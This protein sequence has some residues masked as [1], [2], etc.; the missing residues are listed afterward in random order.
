MTDRT[1]EVRLALGSNQGDR[2]SM[3]SEAR[4]RLVENGLV[5]DVRASMVMETEAVG[6]PQGPF[7]NQVIAGVTTLEPAE[8]LKGVKAIE[9]DMGRVPSPRWGPRLID[10]DI[11]TLGEFQFSSSDLTIPHREI[12]ARE[13]VLG[14]WAT[15]ESDFEIPGTGQTVGILLTRL[16]S[17]VQESG[18]L[19]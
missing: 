13:F 18:E 1:F 16:Q 8:L 3:L 10:I 11:L 14:P 9:I 15:L 12:S 6:P 2:S 17:T 4:R 19:L 7:L 5:A